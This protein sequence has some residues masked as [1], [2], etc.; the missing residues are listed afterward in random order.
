MQQTYRVTDPVENLKLQVVLRKRGAIID[1]RR[2]SPES[3]V[4]QLSTGHPP[5]SRGG[6]DRRRGREADNC[7]S[8]GGSDDEPAVD[9][10]AL[11]ADEEPDDDR[12]GG[13]RR[14]SGQRA[15]GAEEE[16]GSGNAG[17]D[18]ERR[19]LRVEEEEGA[20]EEEVARATF[21]WQQK[22]FGRSEVQHMRRTEQ[23][24]THQS[25]GSGVL[26]RLLGRGRVG[27]VSAYI[28]EMLAQRE[29]EADERGQGSYRGETLH[30]RVHSE[31]F[32]DQAE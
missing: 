11:V 30:T 26:R 10:S 2:G 18:D 3:E 28:Q 17:E 25:G 21:G 22:V 12:R 7:D 6:R 15:S 23:E 9:A 27:H 5:K 20:L 29:R 8:G 32:V 19:P 16:S 31:G 1:R 13:R 4:P 24:R 14:R